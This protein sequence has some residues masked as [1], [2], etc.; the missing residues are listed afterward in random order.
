MSGAA[1][2]ASL[3]STDALAICT[4]GIPVAPRGEA[5]AAHFLT[6]PLGFSALDTVWHNLR[7]WT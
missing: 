3:W 4:V 7:I 2:A 5:V 1:Q 6:P